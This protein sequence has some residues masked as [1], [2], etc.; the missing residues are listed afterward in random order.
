MPDKNESRK[1][2]VESAQRSGGVCLCS[3]CKKPIENATSWQKAHV[4]VC[5]RLRVLR[6]KK[7]KNAARKAAKKT[8]TRTC[9]CGAVF[10]TKNEKRKYCWQQS[11]IYARQRARY[12]ET[13]K[14]MTPEEKKAAYNNKKQEE[15]SI[16][17]SSKY[18]NPVQ[19]LEC[20][21]P[22]CEI[23][24]MHDFEPAYIGR[25]KVP[26]VGCGRYPACVQGPA[27]QGGKR[28]GEQRYS[29][30]WGDSW[31]EGNGSMA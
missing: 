12:K 16:E 24:H 20:K 27:F 17:T 8:Y 31:E 7:E 26:R 19:T 2:R 28:S 1:L 23:L 10:T 5:A 18:K 6:L 29:M 4:D 9:E 30:T 25:Q 15:E 11:C 13:R 3:E 22:G 21:C 14:A